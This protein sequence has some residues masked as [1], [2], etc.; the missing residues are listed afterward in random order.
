[1]QV[2]YRAGAGWAPWMAAG[3]WCRAE[4]VR[5]LGDWDFWPGALEHVWGFVYLPE[6]FFEYSQAGGSMITV[7][8]RQAW[9]SLLGERQSVKWP[10]QNLRK[11][12]KARLKPRLNNDFGVSGNVSS[13]H[14]Q[15]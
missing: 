5:G 1:M 3:A 6:V 14:A 15:G 4:S 11:L 10:V 8:D 13:E 2:F 9:E 12:L 7:L